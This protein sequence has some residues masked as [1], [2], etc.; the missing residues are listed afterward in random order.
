[1]QVVILDKHPI[2]DGRIERH[3]KYFLS[4]NYQVIRVHFNRSEP[5][6]SPGPFSQ[7]GEK[8]YRINVTSKST[9]I[10]TNPLY[11]NLFCS[12]RLI[13]SRAKK[14]MRSMEIDTTLPTIVHVHDPALLYCAGILKRSYFA[15]SKIVYDRHEVY[16]GR[17][18]FKGVK[19]PGIAR[20]YEA[21]MNKYVDGV[22]SVAKLHNASIQ[23]LFPKAMVDTVP[24][25]PSIA[26]YNHEKII[27]KVKNAGGNGTIQLTYVGSLANNYDRDIDLLLTI[28]EEAMR[29]Y[30]NVT[31]SIGGDSNDRA[32]ENR[33]VDL[34]SDFG[35]RFEYLGR[36]PRPQTVDLTE[37]SHLGFFLIRPDTTYWV[38]ASP[39][40]VYE[41]LICG[42][43]P[44][45]RA[46]IDHAEKIAACSLIFNRDTPCDEIIQE[47]VNLLGDP[48]RLQ[49]MMENA[50]ALSND[51][52]FESVGI[53]YINMYNRLLRK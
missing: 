28:Y 14:A 42:V 7:F 10:K 52:T 24:N 3:I 8:G 21:R 11:F 25:Y 1:M 22:I 48:T 32:I 18:S 5:A 47:V 43:V 46:D 36:I 40:K 51:F 49:T 30:Q 12:S 38:R 41:Y 34:K 31:C 33:F 19:I 29:L 44:V 53:N 6:L 2:A 37:R 27:N 16:E 35:D 20:F 13:V 50:L 39:N 4:Q 23:E 45:I 17:T 9:P 15:N 26:D